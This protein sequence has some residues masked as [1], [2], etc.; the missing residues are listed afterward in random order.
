[1]SQPPAAAQMAMVRCSAGVNS[2]AVALKEQVQQDAFVVFGQVQQGG[3]DAQGGH[4]GH[5]GEPVGEIGEFH[6][7]IGGGLG[8]AE[9]PDDGAG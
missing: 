9:Y 8:L 4:F 1:M 6:G 5:G 2:L 7:G 3:P